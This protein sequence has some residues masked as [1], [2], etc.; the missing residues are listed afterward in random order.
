[1]L[2][3]SLHPYV[4]VKSRRVVLADHVTEATIVIKEGRIAAILEYQAGRD[5]IAFDSQ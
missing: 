3:G 4:A 1:M 5:E 2:I